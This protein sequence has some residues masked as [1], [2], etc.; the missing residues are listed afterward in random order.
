[1]PARTVV[2]DE[3][4]KKYGR[5]FRF[6]KTRDFYQMAGRSGRRGIDREGFVYSRVKPDELSFR[7]LEYIFRSNPEPIFSRFNVSYATI[8][9]LYEIFQENLLEIY[10]LSFHYFQEKNKYHNIQLEQ[11]R[12][13]LKIL[14]KLNYI[15]NKQ[16]SKKG[17]FA[18]KIYGY[19]LPI[20]ELYS[21]GILEKMNEKQLG[22]LC[23]AIV[24]EPR[25]KAKKPTLTPELK[26]LRSQSN[27]I[28]KKIH[29]I[30]KKM[31]VSPIS[32]PFYYDLSY[33][34]IEW[35]GNRSFEKILEKMNSDEGEVIRFYRMSIQILREILD[36]PIS[37]DFKKKVK[38]T[39]LMINRGVIDA[40]NQL[41]QIVDIELN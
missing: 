13:R 32:K 41:K 11:M 5:Y 2:I 1:M 19:E 14:K 31:G 40:E 10:P 12:F 25:P 36:T 38:N 22:I 9:N 16:L 35:M 37:N 15:K 6:L 24:Y 20:S 27:R 26:F 21:S 39:I 4:R 7:E 29:F 3:L 8:L 23:L 33:S 34:L 28:I 17:K 18:K 30:E